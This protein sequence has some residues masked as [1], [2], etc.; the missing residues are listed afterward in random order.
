MRSSVC[1]A[2]VTLLVGCADVTSR[3]P[4]QTLFRKTPGWRNPYDW[5]S[6]HMRWRGDWIYV[7]G[8][9]SS[10]TARFRYPSGESEA[11]GR[12]TALAV[13]PDERS[14]L[15]TT[16]WGNDG[17]PYDRTP[18]S[19]R[20]RA[21]SLGVGGELTERQKY[22][23]PFS[24]AKAT[25]PYR[26]AWSSHS[27]AFYSLNGSKRGLDLHQWELGKRQSRVLLNRG[28]VFSE[29]IGLGPNGDLWMVVAGAERR[30]IDGSNHFFNKCF[31]VG[32]R[33]RWLN[34][35]EYSRITLCT[36]MCISPSGK[37]A[38]IKTDSFITGGKWGGVKS[39]PTD[40][41]IARLRDGKLVKVAYSRPHVISV[42]F[43]PDSEKLA[44]FA[45]QQATAD[46]RVVPMPANLVVVDLSEA[47]ARLDGGLSLEEEAEAKLLVDKTKLRTWDL[48]HAPVMT[49]EEVRAFRYGKTLSET[50][51]AER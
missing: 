29:G 3:Y 31:L 47:L 44:I 11:M 45:W 32:E 4:M 13:S 23:E 17:N 36:P 40:I 19:I 48:E 16:H 21:F 34:V 49:L 41:W 7:F 51:G 5:G 14:V 28:K 38:A 24:E 35:I 20:H 26:V 33:G 1:I 27:P 15:M 30:R 22:S 42:A 43:S 2:A 18:Y 37:Y 9:R 6:V 12:V 25:A 10:T 39:S 50:E 8:Y 46:W